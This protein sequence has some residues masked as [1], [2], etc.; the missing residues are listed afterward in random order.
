[1]S[2]SPTTETTRR[3][4]RGRGRIA[5]SMAGT[6]VFAGWI[7][8]PAAAAPLEPEIGCDLD[9]GMCIIDPSNID[10]ASSVV[11]PA[12]VHVM[13]SVVLGGNGGAN[14]SGVLGGQG[15]LT[16]ATFPVTPG[17]QLRIVLGEGADGATP[18]D[19]FSSGGRGGPVSS[20]PTGMRRSGSK[21]PPQVGVLHAAL[22]KFAGRLA[23]QRTDQV[24]DVFAVEV[25]R[26]RTR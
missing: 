8:A 24:A 21:R 20:T 13:T 3:R 5:A 14:S 19:G 7:G 16:V 26:C 4:T 6:L 23:M 1:M 2:S 10:T 11:V 9:T 18:G 17:Q 25:E 15:G 12:D 22:G